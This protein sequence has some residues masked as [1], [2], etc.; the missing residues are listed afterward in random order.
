M[1]RER[2]FKKRYIVALLVIV[3]AWAAY[4]LP[5][6]FFP[7]G[8]TLYKKVPV[9]E[10]ANIYVVQTDAGATTAYSYRY[11]VVDAKV[12]DDDFMTNV[13]DAAPF[14]NTKD[15]KAVLN[16]KD[17]QIFLRVRGEIYSFDSPA[18]YRSGADIHS[19]AIHLDA[20]P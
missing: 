17:N 2:A 6:W 9:S 7:V 3:V 10:K 14:L 11:Y 5:N 18:L 19:V 20:A 8:Y 15:E 4:M 12:S 16:V 1:Q 13:A